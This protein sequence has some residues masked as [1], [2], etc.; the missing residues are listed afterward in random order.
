[1]QLPI[2]V[3]QW[4]LGAMG[5]GMAKLMLQ[6]SG[7]Q[8]VAAVDARPDYVGKDLGEILDVGKKMGVVVTDK[9]ETVLDKNKVDIVVIATTSWAAKQAPDLK[10]IINA[11]I[12]VISI[13]E[14]MSDVEAQSP[15]L[16]KELDDLAK[17]NGV[18]VL[19]T[20]VNP[21]FVL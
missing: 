8:I 19:G 18:T 3:L 13:A 7:L 5:S 4:G 16:G 21:G 1:M 12:N 2:R 11:G 10:K 20:G 14:E 6:K 9:P 17:K 15:K